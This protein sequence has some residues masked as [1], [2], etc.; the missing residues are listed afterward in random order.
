MRAINVRALGAMG[1]LAFVGAPALA[2]G[3][4]GVPGTITDGTSSYTFLG[5]DSNGRA[6]WN[7]GGDVSGNQ[8]FQSWWY[9]R[10]DNQSRE[11]SFGQG[12]PN[13]TQYVGPTATFTGDES[14]A[15]VAAGDAQ[16]GLT[17]TMTWTVTSGVINTLQSTISVTNTTDDPIVLNMFHYGDIDLNGNLGDSAIV[18]D[19][20]TIVISDAGTP[21]VTI[22]YTGS[23]PDAYQI[24]VQDD[25]LEALNDNAPTDLTNV[26]NV[27]TPSDFSAGFQWVDVVLQPGETE[28]FSIGFAVIP[29]P[30]AGALLGL[31]G[32][33]ALRR[34]R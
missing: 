14:D 23:S 31:A 7:P 9:Y 29:S 13:T 26:N 6:A 3:G 27:M 10:A 15:P 30:G 12:F 21:G 8:L 28:E 2:G 22:E 19:D 5:F 4:G 18:E 17:W 25:L 1:L 32:L 11:Y 20:G 16:A 33:G 24:E 34:R